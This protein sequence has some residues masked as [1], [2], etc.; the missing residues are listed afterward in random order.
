MKKL[1]LALLFTAFSI[2]AFAAHLT[3]NGY[4]YLP[5]LGDSGQT[6]RDAQYTVFNVTDQVI[7]NLVAGVNSGW[8]KSGLNVYMTD[9]TS[10]VGIGTSTPDNK[11]V[12]I[13]SAR[14]GDPTQNATITA[15][16]LNISNGSSVVDQFTSTGALG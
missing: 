9:S 8:T 11:L 13:G 16:G 2:N 6:I 7:A 15:N 10:N 14:I 5:E 4:F 1:L 3:T 12:V